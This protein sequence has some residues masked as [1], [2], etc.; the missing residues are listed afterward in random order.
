MSFLA[1][2]STT[3]A[4]L[5]FGIL[6]FGAGLTSPIWLIVIGDNPI[7]AIHN[8][9]PIVIGSI[10]GLMVTAVLAIIAGRLQ[11]PLTAEQLA[12]VQAPKRNHALVHVVV[13]LM[14]IIPFLTIVLGYLLKNTI[15]FSAG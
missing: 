15:D 2:P 14:F 11:K 1:K 8:G 3:L 13:M 9:T 4:A 5:A 10:L 7:Q 6:V 12:P